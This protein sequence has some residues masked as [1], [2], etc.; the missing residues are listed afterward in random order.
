MIVKKTYVQYADQVFFSFCKSVHSLYEEL[1]IPPHLHIVF[2]LSDVIQLYGP[3][4][5][6]WCFSFEILVKSFLFPNIVVIKL[7][8]HQILIVFYLLL[9]RM[10]IN[11]AVIRFVNSIMLLTG[12]PISKY[13]KWLVSRN[14]WY[15]NSIPTMQY[16]PQSPMEVRSVH[17]NCIV[18]YCIMHFQCSVD[19]DAN[20]WNWHCSY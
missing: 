14:N 1:F 7:T 6:F 5:Y 19:Q 9:K 12:W 15:L 3:A 10:L 20:N 4:F 8:E 11:W 2:L 13:V 17:E 16:L 18:G